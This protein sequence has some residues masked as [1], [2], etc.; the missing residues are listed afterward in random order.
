M[1]IPAETVFQGCWIEQHNFHGFPGIH[2]F[3]LYLRRMNGLGQVVTGMLFP[4]R[5]FDEKALFTEIASAIPPIENIAMLVNDLLSFKKEFDIPQ[6]QTNLIKNYC[7]VDG[8][9]LDQAL[10][11]VTNDIIYNFEQLFSIFEGKDPAVEATVKAFS[12]GYITWH[13]CDARY[14]TSEVLDRCGSEAADENFRN[15]CEQAKMVG[16]VD[17]LEWAEPSV[18]MMLKQRTNQNSEI[19]SLD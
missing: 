2:D 5:H 11:R 17:L 14:R 18:S 15:Y 13:L 7:A 19:Q 10:D 12:C 4:T 3:P 16:R 6:E 8:I 9:S 1:L